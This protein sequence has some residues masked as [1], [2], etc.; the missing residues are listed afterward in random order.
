MA[1]RNG[2]GGG[3]TS[4]RLVSDADGVAE[5]IEALAYP[6]DALYE[7]LSLKRKGGSTT[8]KPPPAFA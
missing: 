6:S 5:E 8:S 1:G 7:S 2:K 3:Q 4:F